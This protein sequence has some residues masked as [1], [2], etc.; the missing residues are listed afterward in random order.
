MKRLA[1]TLFI[2]SLILPTTTTY[3]AGSNPSCVGISG[4]FTATNWPGGTIDVACAGDTGPAGCRGEIATIKPGDSFDFNNCTCPP[5][6]S[7]SIFGKS[8]CLVIG[9]NLTITQLSNGNRPVTGSTA[10]PAGCTLNKP[11]PIA[12]GSN[13]D[14]IKTPFSITCKAPIPSP[15]PT[16][17]PTPIP[18]PTHTPTPTLTPIPAPPTQ[19]PTPTACPTPG[20]VTNVKITCPTCAP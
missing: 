15:T 11:Q 3:A 6:A 9:S 13:G 12:C 4:T 16:H 2:L 20:V 1:F 8:G 17:T 14:V 7:E 18:T 19:T 5:Y 10:L